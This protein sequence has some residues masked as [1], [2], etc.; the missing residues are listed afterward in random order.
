[1]L[2]FK[3]IYKVLPDDLTEDNMVEKHMS[4][5]LRYDKLEFEVF[6]NAIEVRNREQKYEYHL[7]TFTNGI[8][9]YD[10]N[11][12]KWWH[13]TLNDIKTKEDLFNLSIQQDIFDLD[14]DLIRYI[15]N[16]MKLVRENLYNDNNN[17]K[18]QK[19]YV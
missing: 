9:L 16:I 12:R 19:R 13:I 6:N 4:Y 8:I 1:M 17:L 10:N 7:T 5:F 2:T 3:E 15:E 18:V 14:L 11:N